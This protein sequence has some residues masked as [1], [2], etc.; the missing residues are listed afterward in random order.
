MSE[1][2]QQ[3]VNFLDA[4]YKAAK[5][6]ADINRL[7]SEKELQEEKVRKKNIIISGITILSLFTIFLGML[8]MRSYRQKQKLIEQE[9]EI[10]KHK[11]RQLENEKML[12]ATQSV[13][14]G[15]E[16]ERKRLARDLHDGLG[17]LLSGV[18]IALNTMKGNVILA[19]ESVRVFNHALGLLDGSITELRRVA[20]NMMPEALVKLGLKNALSDFCLE[21]DKVNPI[22]ILFQFYG[23]F[24]R[25]DSNLEINAYRIVQELVNNS[26]KHSKAKEL[27]VQM[28]QEKSRLCFMVLDDGVGFDFKNSGITKG[29][30]L[31]SIKSRVDAFHG[32]LEISSEPGK[33]CE[34]TVEFLI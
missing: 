34:I 6:D 15:E 27:T 11:I 16:S 28:I 30:G 25:V 9:N 24:E 20:H 31:A 32:Q 19:D 33:G 10:H 3:Q 21:L 2:G 13:L 8:L 29:I 26:I 4:K 1:Q 14:Q 22:H 23:E 5:R 12:L 7:T 17:G 18:K